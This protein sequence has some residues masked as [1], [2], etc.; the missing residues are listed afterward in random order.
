[1]TDKGW[2][3]VEDRLPEENKALL[4]CDISGVTSDE[5]EPEKAFYEGG[6]FYWQSIVNYDDGTSLRVTHWMPLPELPDY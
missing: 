5:R 2:I 1:M 6:I 3:S 4:V